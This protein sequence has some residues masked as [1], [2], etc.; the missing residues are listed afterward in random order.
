VFN[1]EVLKLF[2]VHPFG[3]SHWH[4]THASS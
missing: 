4:F 3:G 2:Q 1:P